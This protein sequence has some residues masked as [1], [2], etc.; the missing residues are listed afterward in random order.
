[1]RDPEYINLVQLT[2]GALFYRARRGQARGGFTELRRVPGGIAA[3]RHTYDGVRLRE[4]L[5]ED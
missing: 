1:M 5:I 2:T 3:F 4:D